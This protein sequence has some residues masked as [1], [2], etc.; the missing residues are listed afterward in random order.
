MIFS[1]QVEKLYRAQLFTRYDDTGTVFYYDA[2]DF[3]GLQKHAYRFAANA[4]FTLQG[5]FYCYDAPKP[6]RLVVFDHGLGGGHRAYMKEIE[7]LA[8]AGYLVFS[9]DHTGCMESEGEHTNGF[10]QSLNDLDACL[11]ALKGERALSGRTISVMGH[12]WGGF[13]TLNIAALH[14]D[15]AHVVAMSGF[16][17][18]EQ[19]VKQNFS[20]ILSPWRKGI[21][22]I[23]QAANPDHVDFCAVDSLQK[24]DAQVLLIY[25][26]NDA[27]V[28]KAYHYDPLEKV[29]SGKENVRLLLVRSKGHS[30][31]YSYS[32]VK[33]KDAFFA[34]LENRTKEKALATDAQKQAFVESFDWEA[35]TEQDEAVWQVILETLEK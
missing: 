22:A 25:S 10:G 19:M 33:I 14:P 17:S 31:N 8:K 15:V 26:D 11:K 28:K 5:Y 9:Y 7:R 6:D 2:K 4:G 20:G 27:L 35:M 21:Y 29:L 24:T 23:E 30:P 16:I 13:S 1:K 12:S 3:P 32:A 18:V 34:E